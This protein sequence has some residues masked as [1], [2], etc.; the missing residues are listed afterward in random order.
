MLKILVCIVLSVAGMT[1]VKLD[2]V[3]L[4]MHISASVVK[5]A[6]GSLTILG[7]MLYGISFCLLMSIIQKNELTYMYP[8]ITG[9]VTILTFAAGVII[10]SEQVSINKVLGVVF[11]IIGIAIIN[12]K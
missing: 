6:I 12:F 11:V 5:I 3:I 2:K 10:F 7:M 9:A 1:L 4:D 8:I